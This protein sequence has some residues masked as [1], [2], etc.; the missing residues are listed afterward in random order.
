MMP[1]IAA[2]VLPGSPLLETEIFGPVMA[3]VRVGSLEEAVEKANASGY[4]LGASVWTNDIA[5]MQK[6][7]SALDAGTV[8]VNQHAKVLPEVPF[9]GV[10][11][12]GL[13]KENG[14][15]VLDDFTEIKTVV[16]RKSA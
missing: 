6:A 15:A 9:G 2:D 11:E 10:K 4:G 7:V 5:V 13:G 16:V 12:S 1:V 14:A 3:V 8:W